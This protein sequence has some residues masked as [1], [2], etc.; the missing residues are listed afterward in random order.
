MGI[1]YVLLGS[2]FGAIITYLRL[3]NNAPVNTE[4]LRKLEKKDHSLDLR[5]KSGEEK[6]EK[7]EEELMS[8]KEV[9]EQRENDLQKLDRELSTM[10]AQL[11]AS[12][13]GFVSSNPIPQAESPIGNQNEEM[14]KYEKQ[15]KLLTIEKS[16]LELEKSGLE[17]QLV[18]RDNRLEK[19]ELNLNKR[20]TECDELIHSLSQEKADHQAS[21]KELNFQKNAMQ[22][23]G[24]KFNSDFQHMASKMLEELEFRQEQG[25]RH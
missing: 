21:K 13:N 3:Q 7:F 19:M 5:I 20:T 6:L 22:S 10:K 18:E 15:V 1:L 17:K 2:A 9:F 16:E 8:T 14:E 25:N 11:D 24:E 23:L 12:A 4:E